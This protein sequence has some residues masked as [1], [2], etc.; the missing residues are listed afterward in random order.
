MR[1]LYVGVY[2]D[3]TGWAR[4]A[5][6]NILALDAA[7][8]D[9]VCRPL[10]LNDYAGPVPERIL[11]LE[12]KSA[13]GCD[14]ALQ[15]V[16]PNHASYSGRFKKNVCLYASETSHFR[17]SSWPERLNALDAAWVFN[18]QQVE[19][20][21]ASGVTVPY[22]IVPHACDVTRFQRSYPALAALRPY[23]EAGDFIF[24]SVGEYIRRKNFGALV[25]AF[26]L[27]FDPSEP[28]QLA[29][30]VSRPGMAPA[31]LEAHVRA[32][33]DKIKAGL[34]LHGGRADF[35]KRE[36]VLAERLTDHG[37]CALHAAGDCFVLP[38]FGEAWSIPAFD[39]MAFGKTPV[40]TACTGFLDYASDEVGWL[41]E[42]RPEPVFGGHE[43]FH[44][45]W[46]GTEEWWAADIG[47][48]RRC[49]RE[50][51]EQEALRKDKAKN[52]LRRAYGYSHGE[53]GALMKG[54]LERYE[55]QERGLE[56]VA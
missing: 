19:A 29:L 13:R 6:D 35:C 7:G 1:V 40:V 42:C 3:S 5:T 22:S 24:Y 12:A 27:E 15:H 37:V 38:S 54:V 46:V 39:A 51:Y 52:G 49:M 9:V 25:R 34:K 30:K 31:E 20:A 48:L 26:H 14:Y 55:Q 4:A 45:L 32:D 28:V 53:V 2:R 33:C 23:K 11:Q 8:V 47:H 56:G 18:R 10:R 50:A 17:E 21:R 43:T 16:L 41:V 44:D 36:I